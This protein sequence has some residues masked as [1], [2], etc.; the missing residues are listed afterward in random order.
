MT[1]DGSQPRGEAGTR[2]IRLVLICGSLR[3]A[4]VNAAVIRTVAALAPAEVAVDIYGGLGR[5]PHFNPDED[6]EGAVLDPEV[7]ELRSRLAKADGVLLCTPEYAGGLPG[8]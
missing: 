7:R 6:R 3:S 8:S 2:S 5:L 1:S 4:S